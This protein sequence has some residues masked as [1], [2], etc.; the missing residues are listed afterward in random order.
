MKI[1]N[2]R[3]TA[4]ALGELEERERSA[5][6]KEIENSPEARA[7]VA[8]TRQLAAALREEFRAE[9]AESAQPWRNLLPLPYGR[10]FWSEQR[11]PTIAIA[12]SLLVAK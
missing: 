9:V 4:Y 1:D 2:P 7:F 6:E 3:L 11:W 10:V 12:A 5:I 8:Q